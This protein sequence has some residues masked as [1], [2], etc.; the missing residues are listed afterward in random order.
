MPSAAFVHLL[1]NSLPSNNERT[2]R[3]RDD[4]WKK[5]KTAGLKPAAKRIE[6]SLNGKREQRRPLLRKKSD[7]RRITSGAGKTFLFV[8]LQ[9]NS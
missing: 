8:S 4:G 6:T 5:K 1:N 2:G 3:V 7:P 9:G